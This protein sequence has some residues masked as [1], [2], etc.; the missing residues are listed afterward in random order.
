MDARLYFPA[1]QRN[2]E[3]IVAVLDEFLLRTG[4][5]VE[6]AAGSGEHVCAFANRYTDLD[7]IASDPDPV[8]RASINAWAAHLG[9]KN[10]RAALDLDTTVELPPGIPVP[11]DAVLCINMIHIAP[12]AACLGLISHA[13][14]MLA[15]GGILYLYGPFKLD[16][17]QTAPS[18][19][20]FDESLRSRDPSWG[21]RE[22]GEVI[23]TAERG[24]FHYVDKVAMPA[25]NY[26]VIFKRMP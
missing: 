26:S 17:Q 22:L 8:H 14:E 10:V 3:P 20:A 11:V 6:I 19:A 15:P 23:D 18:N 5:A 13:A 24:G 12:W 7:W 4:V 21:I 1:T 25:N 2:L 9:L 16:G